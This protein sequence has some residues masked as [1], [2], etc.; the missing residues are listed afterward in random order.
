MVLTIT[1]NAA[2]DKTY[3]VPGFAL[4]RV[5][6][7]TETLVTAGGKGVNVA[8]VYQTLGGA[9]TAT[10]FL[11]GRNGEYIAGSLA[12]EGIPA[13]FVSV[14]GESRL[15]I[16]VIDPQAGTQT[17]LNE[18]G[19]FIHA[20]DCA[21]LLSR[22]RELLPGCQFVIISGS[23]PPGTPLTFYHEVISLAQDEFGVRTVLDASGGPLMQAVTACPFLVKPNQHELTSLTVE[24][25]GWGESVRTLREKYR[26]PLAL[27]TGGARGAVAA[28]DEGIWE[29]IP[30]SISVQSAVGSGDALAAAF[31]WVLEDGGK[32]PDALRLGVAAGAANA[33]TL[34]AGFCTRAS[35]FELAARTRLNQIG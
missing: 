25:D 26:L 24:G 27:V 8:R 19:P 30:P 21:A 20:S 14:R 6:R 33:M 32:L 4:D 15:C 12:S 3:T 22:L 31:L 5:H 7:P 35:I 17:E 13:A 28:D 23:L 1:L 29:A 16:A 2:V 11:G 18:N 9:A 10:G 34:G